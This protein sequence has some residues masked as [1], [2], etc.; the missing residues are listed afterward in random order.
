MT[1]TTIDPR[2]GAL[3]D[4]AVLHVPFDGWS[5][6]TFDAAIADCGI[7]ASEAKDI[8]PR[9]AID[10]AAAYHR[11]GD[12]AMVAALDSTD[13]SELRYSDRVSL[14][15]RLRLRDAD[16]E[17]VRR[18][19]SLFALPLHAAEGAALIWGT[20][21]AIWTALGDTSR[22]GN[23]YSK[24]AILSGVYGSVVLFWLGDQ[25]GG[26]D[27]D[28]FIERR[29]GDVM[30]FEKLKSDARKSPLFGPV[31]RGL[32]R[33]MGSIRAPAARAGADDLPGT[34]TLDTDTKGAAK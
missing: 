31:A 28:A 26:A 6:V 7:S 1:Q 13:L 5:D 25:S 18:G 29:I 24:R 33:V 4:A 32:G 14:A 9:G 8:A 17:V 27:T 22:D 34:W 15:V 19:S 11:R 3:L 16:R 12:A 10:L 20:A 2:L 23:W 21:D 30:R